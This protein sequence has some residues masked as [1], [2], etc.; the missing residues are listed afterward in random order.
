MCLTAL[1]QTQTSHAAREPRV[2]RTPLAR[3]NVGWRAFHDRPTTTG[4]PWLHLHDKRTDYT[5]NSKFNTT[6]ALLS[7]SELVASVYYLVVQLQKK[8]RVTEAKWVEPDVFSAPPESLTGLNNTTAQET[9]YALACR[10]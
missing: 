3:P 9:K 4:R 1:R 8:G 6:S 2:S 5:K 7:G 10:T